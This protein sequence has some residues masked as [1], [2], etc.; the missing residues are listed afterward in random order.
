[1]FSTVFLLALLLLIATIMLSKITSI[2]GT[3]TIITLRG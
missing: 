1:M 3:T 2:T